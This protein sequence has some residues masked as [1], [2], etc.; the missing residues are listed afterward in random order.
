MSPVTIS[1]YALAALLG[2]APAMLRITLER[3][4]VSVTQNNRT[5]ESDLERVFGARAVGHFRELT[6]A[7]NGRGPGRSASRTRPGDPPSNGSGTA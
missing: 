5:A 7:R 4:G 6:E 1:L 3:A 2:I